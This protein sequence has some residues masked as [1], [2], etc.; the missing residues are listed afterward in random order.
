MQ[1]PSLGQEDP[2]EEGTATYSSMLAWRILWT[3]EP[4]ELWSTGSQRVGHNWSNLGC[5]NL[6]LNAYGEIKVPTQL[7]QLWKRR[8]KKWGAFQIQYLDI[9]KSLFN[10]HYSTGVGLDTKQCF[11]IERKE[12]GKWIYNFSSPPSFIE[13]KLTYNFALV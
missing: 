13:I 12:N 7:N 5:T 6:F 8:S 1:V 11:K 9:L 3:E 2:L 10:K 4:G